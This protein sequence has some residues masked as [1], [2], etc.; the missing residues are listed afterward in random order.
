MGKLE[1]E[2]LDQFKKAYDCCYSPLGPNNKA[3]C[4]GLIDTGLK[5][6]IV[7]ILEEA[8]KKFPRYI[9]ESEY[10]KWFEEYFG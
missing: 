7:K 3:E 9:P 4:A 1:D 2:I 5:P 8:K 10:G 6:N